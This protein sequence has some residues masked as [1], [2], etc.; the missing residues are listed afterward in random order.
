MRSN[1]RSIWIALAL[2]VPAGPLESVI[3]QAADRIVVL[4]PSLGEIVADILPK[5]EVQKRLVGA[6]DGTDR[7]DWLKMVPRVGGFSRFDLE[8]VLALKPDLVLA[9]EDGNPAEPVGR[10]ARAGVS[11]IRVKTSTVAEITDSYRQIARALGQPERGANL[12][13]E[14]QSRYQ[15][16]SRQ[17]ASGGRKP[18]VVLQLGWDPLVVVGGRG[19]L[20]EA[21]VAVGAEN[22]F[23]DSSADAYPRPSVEEVVRRK[24]DIVVMVE[25]DGL[26]GQAAT[27]AVRWKKLNVPVGIL[28]S[29]ALLRPT[30]SWP[31]GVKSLAGVIHGT[32]GADVSIKSD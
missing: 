26:S 18:K 7:P 11:V 3:A 25:M 28:Q 22:L 31:E 29:D 6:V 13:S 14:F 15:S 12:V 20:A 5:G 4:A 10:L 17:A 9:T 21:L 1:F 32:G 16:A 27:A 23:S 24:P 2:F 8:A 30:L 19:Y